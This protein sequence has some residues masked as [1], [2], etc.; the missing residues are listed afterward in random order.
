MRDWDAFFMQRAFANATMS[1]CLTR[2]VGAVATRN[3]RS[4]A[5]GFNGNLPGHAHCDE[6]G[7][8]R[9]ADAAAGR[10]ASGASLLRCI[11]VHAEQNLVS[12]CAQTGT[13]L[14]GATVYTTTKPCLDCLKL[15]V[16]SGVIEI[17]YELDYPES[18]W[19][20]DQRL[21]TIRQIG[22][23]HENAS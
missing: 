21:V 4:F 15:L 9:C 3:R 13:P 23:T 5:D 7:C 16:S 11:C 20:P 2:H 6:G 17:V 12:Y 8:Q 22:P 10:V 19:S 14:A 1:T 18:D